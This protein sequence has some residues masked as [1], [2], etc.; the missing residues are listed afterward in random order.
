MDQQ[1][2]CSCPLL[3]VEG[4]VRLQTDELNVMH[5]QQF[6]LGLTSDLL[7]L[8]LLDFNNTEGSAQTANNYEYLTIS[9]MFSHMLLIKDY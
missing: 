5:I 8:S 2:T 9:L 3:T 1:Q 4:V 6:F 7:N